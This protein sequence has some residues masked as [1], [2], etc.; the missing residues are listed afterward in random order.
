LRFHRPPPNGNCEVGIGRES[1]LQEKCRD[2]HDFIGGIEQ[3]H[4]L[5][6]EC[7]SRCK[8]GPLFFQGLGTI[9]FPRVRQHSRVMTESR[10]HH[11]F[12]VSRRFGQDLV[13]AREADQQKETVRQVVALLKVFHHTAI[14]G[15]THEKVY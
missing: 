12:A 11:H 7:P 6:R 2:V 8:K 9:A 13:P 14:M 4:R 15:S 3:K 5:G 10:R 1:R